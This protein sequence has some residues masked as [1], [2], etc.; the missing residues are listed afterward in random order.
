MIELNCVEAV[1]LAKYV[2][3]HTAREAGQA[4]R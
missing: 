1:Q 4:G 2:V 3:K